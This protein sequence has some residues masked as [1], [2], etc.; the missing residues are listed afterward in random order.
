MFYFT[1]GLMRVVKYQRVSTSKQDYENQT[2]ALDK[3]IELLGWTK[4]GE[5]SEV[6][7]GTRSRD[8][9]PQLRKLIEDSR[10]RKYYLSR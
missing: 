8:T 4:V 9:R 1:G 7:S 2:N 6:I 5:Y 10:K 3:Q